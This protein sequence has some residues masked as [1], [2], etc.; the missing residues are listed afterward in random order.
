VQQAQKALKKQ[1]KCPHCDKEGRRVL[2]ADP[3]KKP[4]WMKG[5]FGTGTETWTSNLEVQLASLEQDF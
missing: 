4:K 1:G 2:Q 5:K 3:D